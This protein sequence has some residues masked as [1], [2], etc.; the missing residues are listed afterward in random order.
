MDKKKVPLGIIETS[1][2]KY[3]ALKHN[4]SAVDRR[5]YNNY[6]AITKHRVYG[7]GQFNPRTSQRCGLY[8]ID[9]IFY[10]DAKSCDFFLNF[11]KAGEYLNVSTE[12][13]FYDLKYFANITLN[14]PYAIRSGVVRIE[15]PLN[16]DIELIEMNLE[17]FDISKKVNID[18]EN[19]LKI[20]EYSLKNIPP[21]LDLNNLP[22]YSC[23]FPHLLVLC[24]A[25]EQDGQRIKLLENTDDLYE[26]YKS[27]RSDAQVSD[28]LA[29]LTEELIKDADSDT[30]S[31]AAIYHWVQ[32]KIRY[33]AFHNGYAA[34]VPDIPDNVYN[35]K[36][37]DCKGMAN[38]CKGML[39]HLGFDARL[40]WVYSGNNCFSRDLPSISA[41]NHMICALKLNDGFIYLDPTSKYTGLFEMNEG[42]QGK[43]CIIENGNG[44]IIG[45][46]PGNDYTANLRHI[47]NMVEIEKDKLKIDGEINLYG[48]NKS[49][50][51]SFISD[52]PSDN[53]NELIEYFVTDGDN[54]FHIN[55][56][57][58]TPIDS[59]CERFNLRYEMEFSNGIINL[60]DED[61]V[62]FMWA[63]E[64]FNPDKPDTIFEKV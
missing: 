33:L 61:M 12:K 9:G 53:K 56:L 17:G 25:Y 48:T 14:K 28:E 57:S 21:S 22:G 37:G 50:I 44:Y 5:F 7:S 43:E 6:T 38:I 34:F 54:N 19:N 24:K 47:H 27:L 46:I 1:L 64:P 59:I 52:L 58:T 15:I 35:N 10:H 41:D 26:W 62:T 51:Q 36:Y 30:A 8:E 29:D 32:E 40:A 18:E 2:D 31:I 16:L 49:L 20:I 42:I 23:S 3:L 45:Q 63:N 4:C 60:G 55:E 39:L 11:S 13:E